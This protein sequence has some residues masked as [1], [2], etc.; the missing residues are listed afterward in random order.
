MID[1][2]LLEGYKIIYR[3]VLSACIQC[4]ADIVK[5]EQPADIN[6]QVFCGDSA[7]SFSDGSAGRLISNAFRLSL[8]RSAINRIRL[9]CERRLKETGSDN[10]SG[11]L[12]VS[13]LPSRPDPYLEARHMPHL[14]SRPC[15]F[16]QDAEWEH[17]WSWV[18]MRFR[19]LNVELVFDTA[20]HGYHLKTMY[21]QCESRSN[22]PGLLLI[23]TRTGEVFGAFLSQTWAN[24]RDMNKFFGT[25]ESIL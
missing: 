1:S 13:H 23:E 20:I 19:H 10:H 11:T 9:R 12:T 6:R 24:E 4:T 2:Y 15:P 14:L 3:Y 16:L 17:I 21:K 22:L 18:P 5:H 8:S 7:F 25:P